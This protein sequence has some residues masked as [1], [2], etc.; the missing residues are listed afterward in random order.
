[1]SG[2][3]GS[4][5]PPPAMP[6][7]MATPSDVSPESAA[8]RR[9][10]SNVARKMLGYQGTMLTGPGGLGGSADTMKKQLLGG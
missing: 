2:K 8:A 5:K 4:P 3:S 10:A 9:R 6:A 1:M 7:P